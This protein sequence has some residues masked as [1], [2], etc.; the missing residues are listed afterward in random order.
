MS[1]E[2]IE[3]EWVPFVIFHKEQQPDASEAIAA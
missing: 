2:R 3:Q 1:N